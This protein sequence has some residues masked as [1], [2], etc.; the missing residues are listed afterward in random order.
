MPTVSIYL[1][2]LDTTLHAESVDHAKQMLPDGHGACKFG[3][4]KQGDQWHRVLGVWKDSGGSAAVRDGRAG[5]GG[6]SDCNR[7]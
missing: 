3:P 2:R 1:I 4:R 5:A 6:G 7:G